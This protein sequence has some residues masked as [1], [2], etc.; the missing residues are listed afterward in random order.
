[1]N[2]TYDGT[3]VISKDCDYPD[4]KDIPE[5]WCNRCGSHY[6]DCRIRCTCGMLT[7]RPISANEWQLSKTRSNVNE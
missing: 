4:K 3:M 1:M 2:R 7:G 6:V 5:T